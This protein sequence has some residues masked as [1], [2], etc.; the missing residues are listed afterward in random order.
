MRA[1]MHE[2]KKK[3]V[4]EAVVF[5]RFEFQSIREKKGKLK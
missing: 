3:S 2:S 1:F 4:V 5:I